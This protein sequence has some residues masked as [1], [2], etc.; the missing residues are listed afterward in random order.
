MKTD[1][2]FALVAAGLITMIL[3]GVFAHEKV[4]TSQ[5]QTPAAAPTYA[6]TDT[7]PRSV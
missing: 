5:E 2:I 7:R 3:A 1:R 6:A 4:G